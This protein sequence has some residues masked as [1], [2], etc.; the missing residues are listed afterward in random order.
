MRRFI[1]DAFLLGVLDEIETAHGKHVSVRILTPEERKK[2]FFGINYHPPDDS[3]YFAYHPSRLPTQA[4]IC[5]ELLHICLILEGWPN[6][7]PDIALLDYP[8]ERAAMLCLA[9]L[10]QHVFVWNIMEKL[11]YSEEA[12]STAEAIS[13][14]IPAIKSGA[15]IRGCHQNVHDQVQAA[16]LAHILL[17]P[18]EEGVKNEIRY[19]SEY[20]MPKACLL[21]HRIV[22][23]YEKAAPF[24]P[25]S[26]VS[27]FHSALEIA[28]WPKDSLQAVPINLIHPGFLSRILSI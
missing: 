24:S 6:F 14:A 22:L 11:E 28:R 8:L 25:Q 27:A 12:E 7:Y 1:K 16:F 4:N 15:L 17:C 5:H 21:A 2:Q 9:E 26:C 20:T 23:A 13:D 18:M 19:M 10:T 3:F